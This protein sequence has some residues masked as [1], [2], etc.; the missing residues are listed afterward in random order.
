MV[1]GCIVA[2]YDVSP[3]SPWHPL[4][5]RYLANDMEE[6]EEDEKYEIFPWALGESWMTRFPVFLAHRDDLWH[7]MGFRAV[8]SRRTCEEV[9]VWEGKEGVNP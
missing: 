4:L 8:V 3:L 2:K 6:D 9:G 7:Q 1:D 5:T